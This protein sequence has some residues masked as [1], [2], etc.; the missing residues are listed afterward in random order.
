VPAVLL[1]EA[2]PK[3]NEKGREQSEPVA[4]QDTDVHDN[5][6]TS[7]ITEYHLEGKADDGVKDSEEKDKDK[8]KGVDKEKSKEKDFDRKTE[9]E[10]EKIRAV[11]GA[12]LDN[13]LQRLPGCV[14]RDLIDQL[15][16]LT[17]IVL[18]IHFMFNTNY[19][20]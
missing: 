11:D 17:Q 8:G 7:S 1:G 16:V 18:S 9:R 6:Q 10:K 14:S 3:L 12:S 15:T 13:L 5:P 19:H 2:E 20:S 4:E